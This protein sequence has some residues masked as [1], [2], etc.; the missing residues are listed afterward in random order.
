M[1]RRLGQI[2]TSLPSILLPLLPKGACP[3]C[4]G[5]YG[6]VLS[7]L[8]LGFLATDRVLAPLIV[9][10]LGI[11]VGSVAFTTIGHRR[12]GPLSA[13]VIGAC[14]VVAGRLVWN[15]PALL[16][17]GLSLLFIASLWNLWLKRPTPE[18]LIQIRDQRTEGDL[19]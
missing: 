8:G 12:W 9:G 14:A 13:S 17:G 10:A 5:A 1:K 3:L 11:S 16:Y 18:P 2:L 19:R 7:A 15:V 6:G 4:L